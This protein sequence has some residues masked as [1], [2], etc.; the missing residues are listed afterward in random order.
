MNGRQ[1]AIAA[2][3]RSAPISTGFFGRRA[4]TALITGAN[5]T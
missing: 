5:P 2:R 1:S 4:T 3:T